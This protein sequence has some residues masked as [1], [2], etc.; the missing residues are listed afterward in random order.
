MNRPTPS[1][2]PA[3]CAALVAL[4]ALATPTG[5]AA[6]ALQIPGGG[7]PPVL[8]DPPTSAETVRFA[9]IGDFGI[10]DAVVPGTRAA[11]VATMV[12]AY[13]PEFIVTV[14]DNNY[15]VGGAGT[16]DQNIGQFYHDFIHPYIGAYGDGADENR[17]FPSMG[18]HDWLAPGAW[19]YL[20]YFELPGNERYYDFR[21]GPVHF[22]AL[23]SDPL[24]PDGISVDSEQAQ[25]LKGRLARSDAPFQVVY[26][27]HSPYSSAG[28]GSHADLQWPFSAWGA[29][30]V[31]SG[32]DHVYE[33]LFH[34][35]IH[36]V[37]NGA[38]GNS[39]YQFGTP[40]A[41][42][43]Y[44]WNAEFG[45]LLGEATE[46]AITFRFVDIQGTVLDTF[47][48][49]RSF[50]PRGEIALVEA[51]K[52]WRYLDDGSALGG[53]GWK[54]LEYD[55]SSWPQGKAQLG[56]GD[57][58]E[59]TVIGFGPDPASKH[60]TTYFRRAFTTYKTSQIKGLR[61]RVL[62][63]DGVA[64]YVNGD[65][66]YRSNLP[67]EGTGASTLASYPVIDAEESEYVETR[68]DPRV[69]VNGQNQIAV[70]LHQAFPAS[71]DLSFDLEL[72]GIQ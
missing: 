46:R 26:M 11:E 40:L 45:A 71:S 65:E 23:D 2:S 33:R 54:T 70:E 6:P 24:E 56:Y 19:P 39:L 38:G 69:L 51:G 18:N 12:R 55:D 16:I 72:T 48:V 41:E 66:V 25:W 32:H 61:L 36:Y 17:F 50:I 20:L 15:P 9:V 68:A 53:N 31:L 27:H 14:G 42:S 47:A 63:D 3:G 59:E 52:V 34:D 62:R 29:D 4:L 5:A 57:G 7:Q 49:T 13:D 1:P 35:E 8:G 43:R 30:V 28:H 58:D 21:R 44:R 37:V 67:L 60:V 10:T 22:F 64:V